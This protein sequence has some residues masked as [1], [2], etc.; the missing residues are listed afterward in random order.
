[1]TRLLQI[2]V[3]DADAPLEIALSVSQVSPL[4]KVKAW[5]NLH[6]MVQ[7][8]MKKYNWQVFNFLHLIGIWSWVLQRNSKERYLVWRS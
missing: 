5:L 6:Q 2:H 1:M 3:Q 4:E 7:S 8:T